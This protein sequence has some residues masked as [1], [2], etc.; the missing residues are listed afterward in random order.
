MGLVHRD[1]KPHNIFLSASE[2]VVAKLG[3]FGLTSAASAATSGGFTPQYAPPEVL[4][5]AQAGTAASDVFSFGLVIFEALA[6]ERCC[7]ATHRGTNGFPVRDLGS[8]VAPLQAWEDSTAAQVVE[9]FLVECFDSEPFNRPVASSVAD[10][11]EVLKEASK[12]NDGAGLFRAAVACGHVSV[13]ERMPGQGPDANAR[14]DGTRTALGLAAERGHVDMVGRLLSA[15]AEVNAKGRLGWTPL[16]RAALGGHLLCVEAL[17]GHGAD[18]SP[19]AL[20]GAAGQDFGTV[21]AA[22]LAA[23]ADPN[24]LAE[25]GGSR[26]MYAF[27]AAAPILVAESGGGSSGELAWRVIHTA[28]EAGAAG[29][30]GAFLRSDPEV[31]AQDEDGR[32]AMAIAAEA[33]H[34]GCVVVLLEAGAEVTAAVDAATNHG[35]DD[36]VELLRESAGGGG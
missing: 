6:L 26:S 27:D 8:A 23:G 16:E 1:I 33:G 13:L 35:H 7:T 5:G 34:L 10:L 11:C 2:P 24:G 15:G 12:R 9:A 14:V 25:R 31:E 3:D 32:T 29:A 18:C 28:A 36:V 22:L 21:V 17:L 30:M 20:S 19:L 4:H